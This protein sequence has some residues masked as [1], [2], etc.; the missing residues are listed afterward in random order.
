MGTGITLNF[1][2]FL[3]AHLTINPYNNGILEPLWGR[4]STARVD[5]A[6]DRFSRNWK[7]SKGEREAGLYVHVPYCSECCAFCH[8]SKGRLNAA[9]DL[10]KYV[11]FLV[12]KIQYLARRCP[13]VKFSSL[14]FGGGTP[15][16]LTERHLELIFHVL[17]QELDMQKGAQCTFESHPASL[18]PKKMGV[19]KKLGVNRISLGVQSLDERVLARIGRYQDRAQVISRLVELRRHDFGVVNVDLVAGLP[20][21]SVKSFLEDLRLVMDMGVQ[22][23]HI[24]PCSNIADLTRSATRERDVLGV[25]KRRKAMVAGAKKLLESALYRKTGLESFSNGEVKDVYHETSFLERAGSVVGI[26]VHAM[27]NLRDE[28]VFRS[29]PGKAAL[30]RE[31]YVG[32]APPKNYAMA[33]YMIF[34][35]LWGLDRD[36]FRKLFGQDSHDVFEKELQYLLSRQIIH[37]EGGRLIFRAT[38]SLAQWM[39]YFSHTKIFY[40]EELLMQL[41][42]HFSGRYDPRVDYSGQRFLLNF[43]QDIWVASLYYDVGL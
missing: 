40:G 11:S 41:K 30:T 16:I 32:M 14:Y 36:R 23:V 33:Q 2:R 29:A 39:D 21:Q 8:C 20:G 43:F 10:D 5:L 26:G 4:L 31:H 35:L 22:V 25:L 9:T 3:T 13:G 42:K 34:H 28:L 12:K 6:L 18:S 37:R 7:N 24:N 17:S 27:S 38:S 15:S 1:L 19:L